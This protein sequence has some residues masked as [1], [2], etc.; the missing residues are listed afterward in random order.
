MLGSAGRSCIRRLRR[1]NVS[2]ALGDVFLSPTWF[3][4]KGISC[5]LVRG[6]RR[7]VDQDCREGVDAVRNDQA[8]GRGD[9]S[10]T[11]PSD[12][13][14]PAALER[15]WGERWGDGRRTGGIEWPHWPR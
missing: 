14:Y 2:D 5:T 13:R 6:V 15:R 12:V 7:T 3:A 9:M 4:K 10:A 11:L 8:C 1:L